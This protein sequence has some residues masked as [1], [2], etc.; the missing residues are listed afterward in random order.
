MDK[1]YCV[2]ITT[3]TSNILEDLETLRYFQSNIS[4]CLLNQISYLISHFNYRL[5]VRVINEYT[6]S[7]TKGSSDEQAIN[8]NAFTLIF[9][10]DEIVALG[11]NESYSQ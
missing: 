5:F 7:Q 10:F 2:L 4:Q 6:S 3:K 1:L 8:D 11:M 9:A